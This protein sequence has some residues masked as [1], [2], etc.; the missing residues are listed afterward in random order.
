MDQKVSV[1]ESGLVFY[2]K[3][4]Q[5]H[6][7]NRTMGMVTMVLVAMVTVTTVTPDKQRTYK[8]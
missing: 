3:A 7:D 2:N 4:R 1:F 6:Q 8:H 5:V